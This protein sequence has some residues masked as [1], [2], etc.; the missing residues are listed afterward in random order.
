MDWTF[1]LILHWPHDRFALGWEILQ[2][3]E[4]DPGIIIKVFLG[5]LT[6]RLELYQE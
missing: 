5:I 6:L 1:Y 3:I 2:P 4:E